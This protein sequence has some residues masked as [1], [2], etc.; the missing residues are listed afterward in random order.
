MLPPDTTGTVIFDFTIPRYR[1][2]PNYII[3]IDSTID[4]YHLNIYENEEDLK[5]GEYILCA[6][7]ARIKQFYTFTMK[8]GNYFYEAAIICTASQDLCEF[9]GFP[10]GENMVWSYGIFKVVL[11]STTSVD[12]EF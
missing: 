2:I 3:E 6:G 10:V 11:D 5:I 12:I 7:V 1:G 9:V 4:R 8:P